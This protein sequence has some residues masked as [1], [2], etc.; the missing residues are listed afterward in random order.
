M[1]K[2]TIAIPT[3]NGS[4]FIGEAISSVLEQTFT[5]FELLIIDNHS[6]DGTKTK[7]NEFHDPRIKY[8]RNIKQVDIIENWNN[9]LTLANGKYL[10]I[11]GYDIYY[12][13][14]F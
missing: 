6:T 7:I 5:D 9:C 11:L 13:P 12:V 10:L 1:A 4:R 14:N 2:V 3:L 8:F